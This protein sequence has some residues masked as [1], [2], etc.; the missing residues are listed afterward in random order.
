MLILFI[1]FFF[2]IIRRPPRYTRTD[3]PFPHTTLFRSQ[4]DATDGLGSVS[5]ENPFGRDRNISVLERR[6][7]DYSPEPIHVGALELLPRIAIG[8][9]YDDN[10]Y[11]QP[12]DRIG[13]AYLRIR[14]RFSLVR[15]SPNL[16]LSLDGELD[17]LRSA[18]RSSENA[19]QY[20]VAAGAFYTTT[21][22]DTLDVTLRHGPYHTER[23]SPH[24]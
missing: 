23:L 15:P 22:S 9:G 8:A 3:T 16:K 5:T 7:P 19:S 24:P 11:A 10:L 13:D 14:P 6:R 17:L 20:R 18:D 12:D 4:S 1:F 21:T 2:L